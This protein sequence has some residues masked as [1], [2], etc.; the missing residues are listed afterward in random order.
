MFCPNCGYQV[1]DGAAFC[2]QCGRQIEQVVARP[3]PAQRRGLLAL[4]L[5]LLLVILLGGAAWYVLLRPENEPAPPPRSA[6][7][8]SGD[9]GSTA[10]PTQPSSPTPTKTAATV[11]TP[12]PT[13]SHTPGPIPT[14]PTITPE[15][16]QPPTL[17]PTPTPTASP[18]RTPPPTITPPPSP[19]PTPTLDPGPEN[20]VIGR[21]VNDR[22]IEAVRFGNG[23]QTIIFIGGLHAGFAP[24]TVALA[25]Q[26]AAH[27]EQNPAAIPPNLTVYVILSANP[28]SPNAS[29]QLNGRLNANRVDLNRNWDC[30]WLSDARWRGNVVPDSGGPAPFSEPETQ[31]L[32]D[33]IL[34][35]NPA[36]VIFWEARADNGLVSPGNCGARH[37]PSELLATAYGAAAGYRV[38]DFEVL[39]GQVLN[40]DGTNWLAQQGI[41]AIA[42]LLPQ[43]SNMDWAHNL[44]GILAVL[45]HEAE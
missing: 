1:A 17:T 10:V 21:S 2:G 25:Q 40:G 3:A 27:F 37:Q 20:L 36:A 41:P 15:P 31:S 7:A 4:A 30:N 38:A 26:T 5:S 32:R 43:Y 42:I 6:A 13:A 44:A 19:T 11:V 28:D 8:F 29:G 33:F 45:Q 24:G 12:A 16:T 23:P 39:T 9:V 35:K 34:E 22:P 18:T 14:I